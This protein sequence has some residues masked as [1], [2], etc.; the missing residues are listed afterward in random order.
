MTRL[1]EAKLRIWNAVSWE[2]HRGGWQLVLD[3]I[4][5]VFTTDHGIRFV[6][7]IEDQI[8]Y[9]GPL[10]Y[11][12]VGVS[13]QAPKHD[14]R[15]FDLDRLYQ[16]TAWKQ[17]QP[18]CL[19]I[20]TLTDYAKQF[21]DSKDLGVPVDSLPYPMEQPDVTFQLSNL[22]LRPR[23][24]LHIGQFLRNYEA[25]FC[26]D[27]GPYTK[28]MLI[29]PEVE[30][31][32]E[33]RVPTIPD[34]VQLLSYVPD[35]VYDRLLSESIVFL[36]LYDAVAVTTINECVV[37]GTPIL[38]N[39]VGATEELLGRD[40]P[41][42]YESLEHAHR[43]L[44]DDSSIAEGARY[45]SQT[46]LK[47]K[48]TFEYFCT[49][50]AN[51]AVYRRL[52]SALYSTAKIIDKPVDVA[53]FLC[54]YR[55]LFNIPEILRR[56][57]DQDFDGT[58]KLILWNNNYTERDKIDEIVSHSDAPYPIEVIHSHKNYYCVVRPAMANLANSTYVLI[59][60]DD[61]K[62]NRNYIS[63][64]VGS[65]ASLCRKYR[66][67][68]VV[69]ARGHRF[70]R[71]GFHDLQAQQVWEQKR[72]LLFFD[73][74]ANETEV[75]FVHA[76][77]CMIPTE[78]LQRAAA[79]PYDTPDFILVDDYWLSFVLSKYLQAKL[80]KLKLDSAF[81]F[82]DSADDP[83]I[84]LFHNPDVHRVR[85]QFFSYHQ[86]LQWPFEKM[87][88]KAVISGPLREAAPEQITCLSAQSQAAIPGPDPELAPAHLDL[89]RR[90]SK[91]PFIP[92]CEPLLGDSVSKNVSACVE[93]N[94]ISSSG[95]FV[96]S[97]EEGF[98]ELI[99]CTHCVATSSGTAALHLLLAA[100]GVEPGDEV[101]IPTF[102]MVAVI[103]SV[104]HLGATPVLVD[105]KQ[106]TWNADTAEILA[107]V[108]EK[109]K[110]I[111]VVHTYGSPINV[112]EILRNVDT[113]KIAVLEDAAEAHG[114]RYNGKPAG[115][116]AYGAAFSF[117]ANKLISTGEGGAI[118][119]NSDALA[120][121]CRI[122]RDHAFTKGRHF[123][124]RYRGFNYR[125]T[126]LQAAVGVSQLEDFEFLL[127]RKRRNA[128][129]YSSLL[130]D[131]P[132]SLP[133]QEP[134]TLSSFWMYFVRTTTH[135]PISR[136]EL[137]HRLAN[138]GIETRTAFVPLH[139]QPAYRQY[140]RSG[141]F[142]HAEDIARTGLYL[143]SSPSLTE[144]ELEYISQ[145]L[146]AAVGSNR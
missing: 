36:N 134:N 59:C 81:S 22:L 53:V 129:V 103:S 143:P 23:R 115:S 99:H 114:A 77:N 55:R 105:V 51:S 19:G 60:D 85:L 138:K 98:A 16:S 64:F 4:E 140:A 86:Q 116:L 33:R 37:R 48:L 76:D 35:D 125:M 42:F 50:L 15:F 14:L 58:Y 69:C 6:S 12:W 79:I 82:S 3:C 68:V 106:G 110:A 107:K 94:W 71:K 90:S 74:A 93:K 61:V 45:L 24:A 21:L 144:A 142:P 122:M 100:C 8:R 20:W 137:R 5:D 146:I 13:H 91:R 40:Y 27:A 84:A 70:L 7:S 47:E 41:L 127:R 1:F 30:Q 25:F 49:S 123:W 141:T 57:A 10:L 145:S 66:G 43:L 131:S 139:L 46:P 72:N 87:S 126:N 56:L 120:Q 133:C 104:V 92:V 102:T 75:H 118:T 18:F 124:H 2:H 9:H 73:E 89:S 96:E 39:R 80:V 88:S 109:T 34:N 113:D 17:S 65:Y 112:G 83:A 132:I 121:T 44:L 128:R 32:I 97:F 101:I 135:C 11:P 31:D 119:T 54:S 26:L 28:V 67:E 111:I 117:Y 62:P 108:T 29:D 38:V 130:R 136:D 63:S 78:L 52:P 95:P